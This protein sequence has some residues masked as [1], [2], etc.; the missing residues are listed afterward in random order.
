MEGSEKT[1]FAHENRNAFL[2]LPSLLFKRGLPTTVPTPEKLSL[3][4]L[5]WRKMREKIKIYFKNLLSPLSG[6]QAKNEI[7]I[8]K[9]VVVKVFTKTPPKNG[10]ESLRPSGESLGNATEKETELI[11]D[12]VS[13]PLFLKTS[14]VHLISCAADRT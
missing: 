3:L 7:K 11:V 8:K 1:C 2:A 12:P 9:T 10:R 6:E 13:L 14:S 5:P 4:C